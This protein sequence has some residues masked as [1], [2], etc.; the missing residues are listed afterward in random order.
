MTDRKIIDR[1][2]K[3]LAKAEGTDNTAEAEMLMLKVNQMLT[4]HNIE[5]IDVESASE[6]DPVAVERGMFHHFVKD[7][8]MKW[9]VIRL[10][11][12]YGCDVVWTKVTKNK[13]ALHVAGRESA[14]ITLQLMMPFVLKQLRHQARE[15]A[16]ETGFSKA[17]SERHIANALNDRIKFLH[18]QA[19]AATE[20]RTGGVALVPVD[21]IQVAIDEEFNKIKS[22]TA[23]QTKTTHEA[24][25]RAEQISLHRQTTGGKQLQIGEK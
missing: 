19:K 13:T 9:T 24:K 11:Q 14:R 10:G 17:K 3:V 8:W 4:E 18:Y 25:E 12:L 20:Q 22:V 2:R 1:I 21:E 5:L 15:Y 16:K 23:G 7:S 6:E